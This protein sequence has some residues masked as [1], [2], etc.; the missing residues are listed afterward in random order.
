MRYQFHQKGSVDTVKIVAI[1]ALFGVC[2]IYV[3]DTIGSWLVHDQ[4]MLVKVAVIKGSFFII[5]TAGLLYFLISRY[6]RRL[7]AAEDRLNNSLKY[8]QAIFN[9]INEA[10]IVQ[11]AGSGRIVDVNNRMLEIY[12]YEFEEALSADISQLSEGMSPYSREDAFEKV[13]KARSEASQCFEWHT[14]KKNG[15]LFWAEI[16]IT[17]VSLNDS[18]RIIAVVRDITERRKAEEAIHQS[19]EKFRT[20]FMSLN[21]GFYL[22]EII[23]GDDGN[24]C[25]YRYLEANPKFEEILGISR[26]QIIGKRYKELVPVDTTQ[27]LDNYFKVALTGEPCTYSFYSN[28]FRMHFETYAYQP[29]KGQVSVLVINVTERKCAE[30]RISA[31]LAEKVILLKEVHHRVKNNLQIICSLLD[32]QSDSIPDEQSRSYFRESQNRIRS[33]ALIHGMLYES[34]DFNSIHFGEYIR[35]LTQH[36]IASYALESSRISLKVDISDFVLDI[37]RAIPCGLIINELVS[38]AMKHAFP[39]NRQGEI[40]I[41]LTIDEKH[42]ISL[43]VADT[44]VGFPAGIDYE[45]TQTLGLQLVSTLVKQLRG[46]LTV[47][48]EHTGT[49][50]FITFPGNSLHA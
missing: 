17:K 33:M 26:E 27:W 29:A 9:A 19:E 28:E 38:N 24:P 3:S 10:I 8:Y 42:W 22:S 43:A 41:R 13:C 39:D 16:S 47:D 1:Y 18:E 36:L 31:A 6:V 50:I 40:S 44:G 23:Y 35:D 30:E 37:D 12:G 15:E 4:A 5:C 21:E 49:T 20:L 25:D 7:A 11:D 48:A 2:W 32:L 34:K 45:N 14:R 46:R